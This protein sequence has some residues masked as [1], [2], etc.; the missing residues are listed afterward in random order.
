MRPSTDKDDQ[1][2]LDFHTGWFLHTPPSRRAK[3][4]QLLKIPS[5]YCVGE[6]PGHSK[7]P[8]VVFIQTSR[9]IDPRNGKV[10]YLVV[11]DPESIQEIMKILKSPCDSKELKEVQKSLDDDLELARKGLL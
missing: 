9:S 3:I 1:L 10:N 11:E 5:V 2:Y 8:Q 4:A 6:Y 7:K